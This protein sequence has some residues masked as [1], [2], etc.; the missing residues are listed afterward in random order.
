MTNLL[1]VK[2][3]REIA[4]RAGNFCSY[5]RSREEIVGAMFTI[6]HIIPQ[7]LGGDD[8]PDNLCLA[9]WDYNRI[10]HTHITGIDPLTG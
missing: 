4:R 2:I 5:C 7:A 6:D 8:N 10:K 3:R 1:A 9:C